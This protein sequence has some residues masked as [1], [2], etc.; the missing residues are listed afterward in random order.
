MRVPV[1]TYRLQFGPSLRFQDAKALVPYLAQLGI[2][3]VYASPIFRAMPGST[4][5]YD[6]TDP[7]E[8]NPELGSW[9]DF[10]AL[11]AEVQAHQMGWLQDI[12]PNHMA[13][14][15]E[16]RMLMDLFENGPHSR[17]YEFFDI[18]RDH[19]DPELRARVLAPFLG[20][21]LDEVLRRGEIQLT[22]DD[23]GLALRYFGWRFP[24][25]LTS[26]DDVLGHNGGAT[27]VLAED[28]RSTQA[29]TRLRETFTRLSGM[30]DSSKKWKQVADAK[31]TLMR[32][33][34]EC[35]RI[36]VYLNSVLESYNRPPDG[37]VERSPLHRLLDRQVFKLVFWQIAYETINCRR[38]FYLSEFIA[39]RVED[40]DVFQTVHSRILEL[41]RAGVFTGL[42]V[43][44]IDGLYNPRQYLRRL[45]NEVPKAYLVVEKILDL[46]EFLRDDWP[47]QGTSGYKFCNYVNSIFCHQENE[48]AF[49]HIYHEFIGAAPGY[50]QLLYD[51]KKKIL[52]ERMA[53]ELAYLTHLA[54]QA[55]EILRAGCWDPDPQ[56]LT[57]DPELVRRGLMALMAAFP[58][59][60][61]YVDAGHF[62][63]A[64]RAVFTRAI[65][66]VRDQCPLCTAAAEH[67][68]ELLLSSLR[69]DLPPSVREANQHFLMRFQQFTGPAM[70]KGLEDTLFYVYNRLVSL[71]EV[72]GDPSAF[73]LSLDQFHHFLQLRARDWPHA[74]N[75]T[76][77]HDSKRG[78][79]VR[80]RLNVLSEI[81]DRWRETVTRWAQMNEGH[82]TQCRGLLAPDRNDEYLLY[83]TL[84]GAL[85][86]D[87]H[88]YDAFA[89]RI[90]DYL[91]KA[92]REAKT[93]GNWLRPDEQYEAGCRQFVERILAR[94]PGNPFWADFLPFQREIS[95]YGVYNSLS[96]TALKLTCTGLP[97]FYQGSELWDLSLVDPDNRRP[98]D[99]QKRAHLLQEVVSCR[100]GG[101]GPYHGLQDGCIKLFLIHRG[102][103][104]R[105]EN[106][107]LFDTGDHL[108]AFVTGT[109]AQH[110]VAFFRSRD[111]THYALVVTP[112]FLTSVIRPGEMPVGR[113]V[114]DD[115]RIR[116]PA[117][118]PSHWRNVIT[119]QDL[120]ASGEILVGD[121]L[122]TFPVA[123]MVGSV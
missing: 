37:S 107:D 22:L 65:E 111:A 87:E 69:E 11:M 36:R 62:T 50:P 108:P 114:W 51:K 118:S 30:G 43:D 90:G 120:R 109:R 53:G 4:H 122:A 24:L 40:P 101:P 39:L 1:A 10:Q 76:S 34:R 99:F 27:G 48:R 54:L 18:F 100:E 56:S 19:P 68:V 84:V 17:F 47:I 97:D 102:L 123:I 81:P 12:V 44:H 52:E 103:Q 79:D 83:Q 82:K 2:S 33:H 94:S 8:L 98:V 20:D 61:T 116:L 26:Y 110:V 104:V 92:V 74:M 72:G 89:Q 5:G 93:H 60:R 32:L 31:R 91:I 55:A 88:E 35:P 41:V 86:F 77:T 45:Y 121:A 23:D 95:E 115:T 15:S 63:P 57:P 78:E 46:Y 25:C 75:A 14:S 67:V 58:V 96:Q 70:A 85:P 6:V 38:F 105:R 71:N 21:S 119:G 80:A 106:R 9:E 49:A 112:R 113:Q 29:F 64:D 117:Q 3:D 73:G 7:N 59:Y 66:T 42:R 16:N 28:H 13:Y